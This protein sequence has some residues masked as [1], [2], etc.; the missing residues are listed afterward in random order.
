MFLSEIK[1]PHMGLLQKKI[2]YWKVDFQVDFLGKACRT[3]SSNC[4][5]TAMHWYVKLYTSTGLECNSL[6]NWTAARNAILW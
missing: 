4:A 6:G 2:I 3:A 1:Q 5:H